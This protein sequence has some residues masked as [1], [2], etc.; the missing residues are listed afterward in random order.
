MTRWATGDIAGRLMKMLDEQGRKY[1]L[2][3]KKACDEGHMLNPFI[4][5]I[6]AY[7]NLIKTIGEDIV[8]ANYDQEPVDI[9][10]K[11]YPHFLTYNTS[12]LRSNI[13]PEGNVVL[14]TV[15][16]IADTADTGEDYLCMIIY[17]VTKD[18]KIYILDIYYTQEHMEI[19]EKEA[20]KRLM[21]YE[22]YVFRVES[23]NGGRGWS[24]NVETNYKQLGGTHVIFKPYT[25]TKNKEAR[26]LSNAT[27]VMNNIYFPDD[28]QQRYREYYDS[29]NEYQRQGKNEHDDAED[30]TTAIIEEELVKLGVRYG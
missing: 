30:C 22:P 16:A 4:L 11:L 1:K 25:Q 17:G 20:A 12:L 10:G 19:T 21:Q 26:I 27:E 5:N 3:A 23:N 8:K 15:K 6:K 7:N 28:W 9:K 29:M 13:N 14:Q 24:R 2:I 18:K